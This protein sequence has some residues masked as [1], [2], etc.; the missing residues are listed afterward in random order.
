[1]L[2]LHITFRFNRVSGCCALL[3]SGGRTLSPTSC[4]YHV[5]YVPIMHNNAH[6]GTCGYTSAASR[7]V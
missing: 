1:M 6:A 2:H 7:T 3:A 5:S 4:Q